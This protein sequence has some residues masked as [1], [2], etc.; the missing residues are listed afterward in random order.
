MASVGWV[1]D[2]V[3]AVAW[4]SPWSR[5]FC[6]RQALP[7]KKKKKKKGRKEERKKKKNG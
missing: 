5:N 3:S 6:M 4:F 7:K 1:S 2:I